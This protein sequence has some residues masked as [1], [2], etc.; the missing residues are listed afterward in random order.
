MF[1]NEMPS[2]RVPKLVRLTPLPM[3]TLP[4]RLVSSVVGRIDE[5]VRAGQVDEQLVVAAA[6]VEVDIDRRRPAWS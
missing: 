6:A 5:R 1:S 4:L 3:P 2:C